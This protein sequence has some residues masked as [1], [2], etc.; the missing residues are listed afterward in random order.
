MRGRAAGGAGRNGDWLTAAF[1]LGGI[2]LLFALA[3]RA[4]EGHAASFLKAAA[5]AGVAYILTVPIFSAF[6]LEIVLVP[7]AAFGLALGAERLAAAL[8]RVRLPSAA[9]TAVRR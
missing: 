2:L 9:P 5:V 7:M 3:R 4:R 6:R 8:G 1:F